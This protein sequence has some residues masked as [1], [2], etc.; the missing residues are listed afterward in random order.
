[1]IENLM[2]FSGAHLFFNI[3]IP[4]HTQTDPGESKRDKKII[5]GLREIFDT[6]DYGI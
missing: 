4:L 5:S 3:V 6:I 1:M 2:K